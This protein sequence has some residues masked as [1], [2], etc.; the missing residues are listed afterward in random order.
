MT[1]I[2]HPIHTNSCFR[3]AVL[4]IVPVSGLLCN[5]STMRQPRPAPDIPPAVQGK[6]KTN[7][8]STRIEANQTLRWPGGTRSKR[9]RG[10]YPSAKF[11]RGGQIVPPGSFLLRGAC[12]TSTFPTPKAFPASSNPQCTVGARLKLFHGSTEFLPANITMR[13][14]E[15][16]LHQLDVPLLGR[17]T[18]IRIQ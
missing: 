11:P 4:S 5:G 17:E 14:G 3:Y 7:R 15:C 6:A 18:K 9:K 10:P 1:P 2:H 8:E 12:K 13:V 16:P